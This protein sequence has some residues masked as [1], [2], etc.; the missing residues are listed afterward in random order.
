[1]S[2]AKSFHIILL[3]ILTQIGNGKIFH[4]SITLKERYFC[5]V[6]RV[7]SA[8]TMKWSFTI[9]CFNS[10]QWQAQPVFKKVLR[11][12]ISKKLRLNEQTRSSDNSRLH[13][14]EPDQ[15][16]WSWW[17]LSCSTERNKSSFIIC[18]NYNQ[19]KLSIKVTFS[20]HAVVWNAFK[21]WEFGEWQVPNPL[22]LSHLTKRT[23][24]KL[25]QGAFDWRYSGIRIN[26]ITTTVLFGVQ[27]R[28]TNL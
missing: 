16:P 3:L 22:F 18:E 14:P 23:C 9:Y 5:F 27:F 13:L 15:S 17:P 6:S 24:M 10:T 20:P 8:W 2:A 26:G 28:K 12:Y 21:I 11:W 25:I 7:L 1:M 4:R 19:Q